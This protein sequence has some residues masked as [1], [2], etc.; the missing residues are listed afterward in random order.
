MI[1]KRKWKNT[2]DEGDSEPMAIALNITGNEQESTSYGYVPNIR[3]V[4][5]K[6]YF[7]ADID[8][9]SI[10][11]LNRT[12]QEMDIKLQN[13]KAMLGC[14]VVCEL[15]ICSSGGEIMPA[16]GAVDAIRNM[17]S[18]VHTYIDGGAASAATLLSCVG[19]KRFIG[20][21]ATMLIHQLSSGIYGKFAEIEDE[22]KNLEDCMKVIKRFYK[23]Y[24]KIPMKRL[25]VILKHDLWLQPDECLQYGMV[26]EII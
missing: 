21:H 2:T 10:L 7:Y 8:S 19:D 18:P 25:D 4:D 12:L 13:T 15:H 17:K 20:K 9:F 11:E 3:V 5:N 14:E 24:T 26:D 6:I 22:Y 16:F 1:S 23:T